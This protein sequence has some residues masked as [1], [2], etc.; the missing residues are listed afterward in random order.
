MKRLTIT[1]AALSLLLF[2]S[3]ASGAQTKIF[4]KYEGV[5]QALLKGSTDEAQTAAKA[6]AETA[7]A[8]KQHAIAERSEALAAAANLKG[9]RDSFAM[10][11]EEV[12]QFR[13]ARSGKRPEVVYCSMHKASWLQ[14]KGAIANPYAEDK[15]MLACGE[16]RKDKPSTSVPAHQGHH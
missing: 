13:D 11:S 6:L 16:F 1:L 15:S 4:E 3:V 2:A 12:I 9:A 14:P 10:L 5:R 7:R 8:E